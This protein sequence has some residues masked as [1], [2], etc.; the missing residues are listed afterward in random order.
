MRLLIIICILLMTS[1]GYAE[2][3]TFYAPEWEI[4]M[5][6]EVNDYIKRGN[7]MK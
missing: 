2:K 3:I 5:I 7:K 6:E 4:F 1:T